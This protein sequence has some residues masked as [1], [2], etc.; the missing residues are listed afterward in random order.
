MMT[1]NITCLTVTITIGI[2]VVVFLIILDFS[3]RYALI[4]VYSNQ[5]QIARMYHMLQEI[6]LLIA[7]FMCLFVRSPTVLDTGALCNAAADPTFNPPALT[8]SECSIVGIV[9]HY[10][11]FVHFWSLFLEVSG[12]RWHSR[13]AQRLWPGITQL[14]T[15][16]VCFRAQANAVASPAL[17]RRSVHTTSSRHANGHLLLLGIHQREHVLGRLWTDQ[18]HHRNRTGHRVRCVDSHH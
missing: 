12:H 5:T 3:V 16:H 7:Q 4:F 9:L 2:L 10:L 8:D 1:M 6:T 14:Y 13:N 11:Y 15:V 18:F 17:A